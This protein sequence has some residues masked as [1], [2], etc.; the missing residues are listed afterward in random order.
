VQ[1]SDTLL[2]RGATVLP[3]KLVEM[4]VRSPQIII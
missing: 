1:V 4:S 2:V 3:H